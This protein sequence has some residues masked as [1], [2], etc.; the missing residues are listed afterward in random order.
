MRECRRSIRAGGRAERRGDTPRAELG[1]LDNGLDHLFVISAL[2]IVPP[3]DRPFVLA[4]QLQIV[5]GL[6]DRFAFVALLSPETASET[7]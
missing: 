2:I 5:A 4:L 6:A 1:I 3:P 7:T